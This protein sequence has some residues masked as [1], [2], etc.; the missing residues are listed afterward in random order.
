MVANNRPVLE[1]GDKLLGC[2][3][4]TIPIR[5]NFEKTSSF[6]LS[7]YFKKLKKTYQI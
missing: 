4:N 2:F 6:S 3:L 7:D 1:D 5:N